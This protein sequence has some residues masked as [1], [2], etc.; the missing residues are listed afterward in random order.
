M[1]VR[2]GSLPFH[3]QACLAGELEAVVDQCFHGRDPER[4]FAGDGRDE[5]V[6]RAGQ[7]LVA[8]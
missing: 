1:G 5:V 3:P 8:D 4:A 6:H 2:G 7:L